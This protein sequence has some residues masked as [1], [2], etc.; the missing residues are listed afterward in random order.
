MGLVRRMYRVASVVALGV[1]LV[2]V[3]P[4]RAHGFFASTTAALLAID[5]S[6]TATTLGASAATT[7]SDEHK[8]ALAVLEEAAYFYQSGDMTGLLPAAVQRLREI[9]PS[10]ADASNS[11]L[12][13][14]L[15]DAV[16][17][18]LN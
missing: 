11:E 4:A 10:L 14:V 1:A 9:E 17:S 15:V 7:A 16:Q 3:S 12:V 13:G 5:F 6:L 2:S 8:I 18:R